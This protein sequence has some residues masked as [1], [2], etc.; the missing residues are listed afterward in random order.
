MG[1]ECAAQADIP[2]GKHEFKFVVNDKWVTSNAVFIQALRT[3]L[4]A[5]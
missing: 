5:Q 3:L 1:R 2:I 4:H